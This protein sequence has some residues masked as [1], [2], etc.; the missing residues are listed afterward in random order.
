MIT[1]GYESYAKLVFFFKKERRWG[2]ARRS[3][4]YLTIV[5]GRVIV[6][7]TPILYAWAFTIYGCE[8]IRQTEL[9]K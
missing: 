2:L 5:R 6:K 9:I 8:M 4:D 7:T 3:M 1:I